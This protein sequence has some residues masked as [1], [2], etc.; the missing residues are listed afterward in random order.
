MARFECCEFLENFVRCSRLFTL[1]RTHLV[2]RNDIGPPAS[3][4]N[5]FRIIN[6]VVPITGFAGPGGWND[7][8]MLEVGN[9]GL[10]ADEQ[11][12][13]ASLSYC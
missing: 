13:H 2:C 3:W 6:Q 10:S 9:S 7:L 11:Q 12:T 5:L 4:D 1:P 8:D